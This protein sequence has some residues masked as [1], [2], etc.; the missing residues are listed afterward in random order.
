VN[1]IA[2]IS[3]SLT[4]TLVVWGPN[5][6]ADWRS[7]PNALPHV[8]VRF[9]V[10]FT[11][12]RIAVRALES[13]VTSYIR[14]TKSDQPPINVDAGESWTASPSRRRADGS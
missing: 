3:A 11:V 14:A 7:G 12:A 6:I 13:L 8:S 2:R 5:A 4:L 1:P 9:L 10:I